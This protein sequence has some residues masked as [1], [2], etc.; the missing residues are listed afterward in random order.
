MNQYYDKRRNMYRLNVSPAL[1]E[2]LGPV[3]Q[4]NYE[5]LASS[6][7]FYAYA[8]LC[9]QVYLD[10]FEGALFTVNQSDMRAR[11]PIVADRELFIQIRDLGIRLAEL[12]KAEYHPENLLGF[13]Y[14]TIC[15]QIP[16]NFHLSNSSHPFDEENEELLLTDGTETIKIPCPTALQNLNIS[17]YDVVKNVW[18]KFNS[19][20]F[21]HC[22]F[23]P[24]DA[25]RLLN[26]LNT[27][28]THTRIVAEIDTLMP[29]VLED[30]MPLILPP[31]W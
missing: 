31:E 16:R 30:D 8:I 27:L 6:M 28:E 22:D 11:I 13:D 21:T 12:E 5:E 7:V 1:L 19:Y 15:N 25:E 20:N 3:L 10:E 23:T 2:E 18:L 17:G 24:R 4:F 26:F 9:S 14:D 29:S